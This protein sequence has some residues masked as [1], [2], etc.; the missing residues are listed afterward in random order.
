MSST[1]YH[2]PERRHTVAACLCLTRRLEAA[3]LRY[4][5]APPNSDAKYQASVAIAGL[6]QMIARRQS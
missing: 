1:T 4:R 6:R 3:C 5:Q 2:G